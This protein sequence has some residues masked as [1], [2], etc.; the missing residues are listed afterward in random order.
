[1]TQGTPPPPIGIPTCGTG[2]VLRV[3]SSQNILGSLDVEDVGELVALVLVVLVVV[4]V[5]VASSAAVGT[6]M[7]VAT[8]TRM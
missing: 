8:V 1:M 7:L 5:V 4:S 3:P 6:E 2:Y